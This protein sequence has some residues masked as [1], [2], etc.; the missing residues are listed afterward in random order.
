MT[1]VAEPTTQ[2]LNDGMLL[3]SEQVQ[4]ISILAVVSSAV[5]M[6]VACASFL[7]AVVVTGLWSGFAAAGMVILMT[8]LFTHA[9]RSFTGRPT[10]MLMTSEDEDGGSRAILLMVTGLA[11]TMFGSVM[12]QFFA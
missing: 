3:P 5:L 12:Y 10:W 11:L 8:A 2:D 1:T 9:Y 4:G 7:A 6:A